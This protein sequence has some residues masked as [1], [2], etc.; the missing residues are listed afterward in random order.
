[1]FPYSAEIKQT[2]SFWGKVAGYVSD[3]HHSFVSFLGTC[4]GA[5]DCLKGIH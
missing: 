3:D 2:I 1:M 4:M 5:L